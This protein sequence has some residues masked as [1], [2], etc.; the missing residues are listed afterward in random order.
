MRQVTTQTHPA[1]NTTA[2]IL[3]RFPA[4]YEDLRLLGCKDG[5]TDTSAL[6]ENQAA[7]RPPHHNLDI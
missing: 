7:G 5:I 6:G 2:A 4:R 3:T 1:G